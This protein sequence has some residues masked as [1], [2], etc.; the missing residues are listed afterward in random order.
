VPAAVPTELRIRNN[1]GGARATP[2]AAAPPPKKTTTPTV[3]KQRCTSAFDRLRDNSLLTL[4][5]QL[6]A[7][8]AELAAAKREQGETQAAF[9]RAQQQ[10]RED[11]AASQVS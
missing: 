4:Q 2:L 3:Q 9:E 10:H 1:S 6:T 11:I 8:I 7:L 5:K